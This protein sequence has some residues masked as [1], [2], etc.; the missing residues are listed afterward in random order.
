M[1]IFKYDE[2]DFKK[3]NYD[4][5]EKNG[6]FYYSSINYNK[7]PF[8]ILSPKMKY[9]GDNKDI[10]TLICETINKD[11]S[12]YDFFLNLE[13]RNIKNTFNSNKEWFGKEIPLDLIDDMYKRIIKP[14]KKDSNP[15]FTFKVPTLKGVPQCHIYN[16]N[17]ICVDHSKLTKDSE[18]YFTLHIKGLKFL[19]QHF[20]C[21]CYVSQIKIMS[22]RVEKYMIIE[23]CMI[24]DDNGD[25]EENK[26]ED[27]YILDDNILNEINIQKREEQK[28]IDKKN[29]LIEKISN[30]QKE[31]EN[32]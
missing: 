12:F 13:N 24:D 14:I 11:F 5:P 28:K 20:Y 22:P 2:I 10:N 6:T 25:N 8:H 31:L 4:K 17:K 9:I 29:E 15:I 1:N 32:L 18:I 16:Q 19:K 30:L 3:I 26:E 21:D 7:K 23:E 27:I